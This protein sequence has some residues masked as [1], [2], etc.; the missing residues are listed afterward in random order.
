MG[1][2]LAT[3]F[4]IMI[5]A[6]AVNASAGVNAG[7][8]S[9]SPFIGGYTADGTQNR[10]TRLQFGIRGG[11]NVTEH[12]GMEGVFGFSSGSYG[13]N[14]YTPGPGHYDMFNY[15]V[16]LLYH[17]L[18]DCT[19]VP[20]VA[21]GVGGVSTLYSGPGENETKF[22]LN[23]GGGG[24]Y[25]LSDAAALRFDVRGV[26]QKLSNSVVANLFNYEYSVGVDF[27]LGE[28]RRAPAVISQ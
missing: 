5:L 9:V 21:G 25:F 10:D 1:K 26:M 4:T 14:P 11:Y 2:V 8:F 18:P 12:V 20:Y 27:F 23:L 24:R 3:L 7:T 13:P 17:F 15:R 19:L 22:T 6:M 16:D 28:P